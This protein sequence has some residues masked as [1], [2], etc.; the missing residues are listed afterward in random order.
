MF[1]NSCLLFGACFHDVI[2]DMNEDPQSKGKS[3]FELMEPSSQEHTSTIGGRSTF[4]A[5][6]ATA[7]LSTGDSGMKQTK[8]IHIMLN[9]Q[10]YISNR[11]A[12]A[13]PAFLVW[14]FGG[15]LGAA[16]LVFVVLKL[17]GH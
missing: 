4:R 8:Q 3:P 17:I 7:P 16:L 1:W 11:R 13:G 10:S 5:G 6:E 15:G 9:L 2:H 12:A 14:L